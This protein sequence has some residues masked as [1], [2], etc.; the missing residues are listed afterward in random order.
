MARLLA[1]H[2]LNCLQ[3]SSLLFLYRN[4]TRKEHPGHK[5]RTRMARRTTSCERTCLGLITRLTSREKV[6]C[7]QSTHQSPSM[8]ARVRFPGAHFSKVPKSFRTRKAITKISNLKFTEL[9]FSHIFNMNK[10]VLHAKFYAY[11][12][13]CFQ[14]TGN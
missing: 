7:K 11:T 12:L 2:P 14:D 13:L 4:N 3:S 8:L 9:F 6:E 1:S 5:I 10:V